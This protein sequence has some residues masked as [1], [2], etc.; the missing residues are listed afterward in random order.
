MTGDYL[1]EEPLCIYQ[2]SVEHRAGSGFP[3]TA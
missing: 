3:A 2:P 1:A